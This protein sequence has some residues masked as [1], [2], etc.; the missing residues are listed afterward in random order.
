MKV[1][2]I[3]QGFVGNAIKNKF[4]QHFEVT[5]YDKLW[6]RA[7]GYTPRYEDPPFEKGNGIN[8][9]YFEEGSNS[10]IVVK[11]SDIIFVCLPTPMFMDTGEC[12][13][14][15]VDGVVREL[16]QYAKQ[17]GKRRIVIIKSTVP[18]GTTKR[19]NAECDY[20]DVCFSPEFLT[21]ANAVEDFNNQN[22][23]VIGADF[24]ASKVREMFEV[25][26]PSAAYY[27]MT[28]TESEMVKYTANLFLATK[29]SFFNDIYDVCQELEIDYDKV[30]GVAATDKRIGASHYQVPGPDGD[31]GFGGH[32]FPKDTAAIIYIAEKNNIDVP[33]IRGMWETNRN[34]RKN[35]DWERMDGR[36][37]TKSKLKEIK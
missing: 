23:I 6:S 24:D 18:P 22:R 36:A 12:D 5:A 28:T 3:G 17:E 11:I 35:K 19:L 30:A 29:V 7:I 2:I 26:F 27:E 16:N 10:E 4:R 14:S 13:T 15:I 21:E 32:C 8:D 9:Y 31:R 20:I 1:G 25:C 33:T 34:V 37:V